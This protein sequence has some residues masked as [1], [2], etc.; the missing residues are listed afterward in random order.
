MPFINS[1]YDGAHLFYRDYMP[2]LT[3]PPFRPEAAAVNTSDKPALVFSHSWPMSSRMYEHLILPLCETHRYRCIA[4]DRRGFGKSEWCGDASKAEVDGDVLGRDLA[5]VLESVPR[6][7]QAGF[8]GVGASMA[9]GEFLLALKHDPALRAQCKGLVLL[10]PILPRPLQTPENPTAPS[11]EFWDSIRD[12]FRADRHG[13]TIASIPDV[14]GARVGIELTPA[15][16]S[17]YESM[18]HEADPIALERCVAIFL[19]RDL[20]REVKE[21]GDETD[22][23]ILILYGDSDESLPIEAGPEIVK[24]LVPRT[25]IKLY[26]KAA[27]GE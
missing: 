13:F 20:T 10:E 12:G 18:V 17:R 26:E 22:I 6:P 25:E 14:F 16:K 1:N 19:E 15:Q 11:R 23:P 3:P 24:K 2:T 7:P 27:H 4:P 5:Q 21:F 8:I 9:G